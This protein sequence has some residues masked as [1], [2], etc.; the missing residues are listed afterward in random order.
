MNNLELSLKQR[1]SISNKIITSLEIMSLNIMELSS[2]L[3]KESEENVFID[4]DSFFEDKLF[5]EYIKNDNNIIEKDYI[6]D[7]E[8][9]EIIDRDRYEPTLIEV[10]LE[11]LGTSNLTEEEYL[12]GELIIHSLDHDGYMRDDLGYIAEIVHTDVATVEKVL[13]VIKTFEPVGIGAVNL[14]ECLI[15]QLGEDEVLV[16]RIIQ[17]NINDIYRNNL[18]KIA[19]KENISIEEVKEVFEKIKKLNPRPSIGYKT[20]NYET[21]YVYPD[22]FV[23]FESGDI[24]VSLKD[25]TSNIHA[26]KYYLS[27]L[28]TNIDDETKTYLK[29]KLTRTMLIMESINKRK[30]TIEKIA[31][32]IIN[33]QKN[34]ILYDEPLKDLNVKDIATALDL[35]E[36]TVSRAIKHKYVQTPRHMYKLRN[37]L[38]LH[39]QHTANDVSKNYIMD[40]IQKMIEEEDKKMPLSDDKI[41]DMLNDEGIN[42]K[43]RT[44]SKY[45]GKMSI[46]TA[47]LRK[48]Y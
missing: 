47:K 37:L 30:E 24:K 4:Y 15:L 28:D 27:L 33:S 45:R 13:G 36:S 48:K 20:N 17:N 10:L 11:Q 29:K 7:D 39:C 12:V 41:T 1:L 8:E 35:S 16:R 32:F 5:R 34:H 44:V 22:I 2:F 42:I 23:E 14:Q 46:P 3:E 26:N 25:T 6:T 38:S 19:K 18:D 31:N 9:I 40:M 21:M 43:R